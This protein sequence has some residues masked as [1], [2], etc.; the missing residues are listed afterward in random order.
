MMLNTTE[1]TGQKQHCT[2]S[3]AVA[4]QQHVNLQNSSTDSF[5]VKVGNMLCFA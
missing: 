3:P 4:P 2:I 1:T 5:V